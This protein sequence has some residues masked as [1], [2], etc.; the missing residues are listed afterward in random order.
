MPILKMK[1]KQKKTQNQ[2]TPKT[3]QKTHINSQIQSARALWDTARYIRNI[4]KELMAN[5]MAGSGKLKY[6]YSI[7]ILSLGD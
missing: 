7:N 2:K 4:R 1:N 3:T 6:F 5:M